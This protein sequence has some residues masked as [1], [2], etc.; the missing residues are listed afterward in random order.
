MAFFNNLYNLLFRR[1]ALRV[2]R[3]RAYAIYLATDFCSN[4]GQW[5]FRT[6]VGW[7]AWELSHSGFWLGVVALMAALPFF[8]FMPLAGAWADES[9]QPPAGSLFVPIAQPR[10]R[11]VVAWSL[12]AIFTALPSVGPCSAAASVVRAGMRDR[13]AAGV[14]ACGVRSKP[15]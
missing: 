14:T 7:L 13:E 11:L 2:F 12:I 9:A 15:A 10:A 6:G 5:A 8:I 3:H 1:S 4:T